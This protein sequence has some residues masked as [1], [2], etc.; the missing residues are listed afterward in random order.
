MIYNN[1]LDALVDIASADLRWLLL[2]GSGYT[3]SPD[4]DTVANLTPGS[5]E[6]TASG[7]A[8]VALSGGTRT[9]DDSTDR[10]NYTADNPD[11]GTLAAGQTITAAVLYR[12]VTNDS[13]SVPVAYYALSPIDSGVIDP[14]VVHFTDGLLA[15]VDEA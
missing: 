14:Y 7:Y 8:R 1:G 12:H 10:V 15:W 9:V 2:K 5:N 4:H 3:F 11:F 13:D 6:V